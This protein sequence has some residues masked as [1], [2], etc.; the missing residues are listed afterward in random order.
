M[1]ILHCKMNKGIA[2]LLTTAVICFAE[3]RNNSNEHS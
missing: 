2:M 3:Y 1:A